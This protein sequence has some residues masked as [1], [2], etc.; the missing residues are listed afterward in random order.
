MKAR[1]VPRKAALRKVTQ[2]G[3]NKGPVLAV[4]YD[5]RLPALGPIVAKHWRSMA[6]RDAYLSK[7]FKRPPLIAFKRQKNLRENLIKAKVP[8]SQKTYPKQNLRGM[9][10]CGQNC[11]SIYTIR[12]SC[13]NQ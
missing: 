2:K 11:T 12:K 8:D 5:P 10:K 13:E 1:N 3:K 6:S 9:S 4:T 7:V